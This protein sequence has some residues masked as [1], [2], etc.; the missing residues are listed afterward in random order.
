MHVK[1]N[2]IVMLLSNPVAESTVCC[3]F[4]INGGS[5]W[6]EGLRVEMINSPG[7]KYLFPAGNEA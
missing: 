6:M 3:I 2:S 4:L 7:P 1:T 5:H